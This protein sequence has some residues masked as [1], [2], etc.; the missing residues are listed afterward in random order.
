MFGRIRGT[1]SLLKNFMD[2]AGTVLLPAKG[3]PIVIIELPY[4]D[5]SSEEFVCKCDQQLLDVWGEKLFEEYLSE[6]GVSL[7][8]WLKI[9][10]L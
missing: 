5:K 10:H 6:T 1:E 8:Q 7:N 4:D 2:S 3:E 9:T